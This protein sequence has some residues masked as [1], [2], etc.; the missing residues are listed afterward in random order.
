MTHFSGLKQWD[1]EQ[2]RLE[3]DEEEGKEGLAV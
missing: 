2:I 3:E 1:S